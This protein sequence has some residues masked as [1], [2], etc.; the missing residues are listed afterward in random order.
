[1]DAFILIFIGLLLWIAVI[2]MIL[3]EEKLIRFE[4]RILLALSR[5]IP[6]LKNLIHS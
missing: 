5:K 1:M 4:N 3:H 6:A 2:P